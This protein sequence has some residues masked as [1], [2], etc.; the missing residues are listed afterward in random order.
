MA[1]NYQ[2]EYAKEKE[3]GDVLRIRISKE[4]HQKFVEKLNGETKSKWILDKIQEF[5]DSN[6]NK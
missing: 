2:K 3:S 4:L 1:R 5:V 6:E